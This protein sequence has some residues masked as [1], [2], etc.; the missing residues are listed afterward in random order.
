MDIKALGGHDD[1][2]HDIAY[3]YYG[4]RL[5]TCSSDHKVKVYDLSPQAPDSEEPEEELHETGQQ[6]D[7]WTLNDTWRAHDAA[8]LK[9]TWAS[10]EY[11]QILATCSFDRSIRIWEE[12]EEEPRQSEKRW[13]EKAR[14]VDS[15]GTVHDIEFAPAHCGLKIATVAV[16]GMVRIYEAMD[17]VNLSHWTLMEDL[18]IAA[19]S[20]S[21]SAST[22]A[23]SAVP[24]S[25]TT[26]ANT[27]TTTS[28]TKEKGE[29][30]CLSWC[31]SRFMP[32]SLVVGRGR[33]QVSVYRY[34]ESSRKWQE[35]CA[36]DHRTDLLV[37]DVSWAPSIGRSY[38][39][40]ATA[41]KDKRVRI[42]KLSPSG[43]E[44]GDDD[45]LTAEL[46]A[47]LSAHGDEVWRVEWNI[48]GTVLASSGDDGRVCLWKSNYLNEWSQMSTISHGGGV[49]GR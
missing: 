23:S 1:L 9:V 33:G 17:I 34:L 46:V 12:Q 31:K 47:D 42:F 25:T 41:C 36:L 24:T 2:I 15:R 3:D 39:L 21:A 13:M 20:S 7:K 29:E 40:I 43:G 16:D 14:L 28:A 4:R 45:Q 5:A 26:A 48:T 27:I 30:Y 10:P 8:I 37:H 32:P 49:A 11:G 19:L 38:Q 18:N 35:I 22:A 44:G 6:Q